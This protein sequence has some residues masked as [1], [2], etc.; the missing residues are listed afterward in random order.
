M[1]SSHCG[2]VFSD[3]LVVSREHVERP[4][5]HEWLVTRLNLSAS[6]RKYSYVYDPNKSI[7]MLTQH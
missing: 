4:I 1:Q 2:M 5:R 6:I 7:T 3:S